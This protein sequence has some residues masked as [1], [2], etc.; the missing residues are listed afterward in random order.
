MRNADVRVIVGPLRSLEA[1]YFMES[2]GS[3]PEQPRQRL[4]NSAEPAHELQSHFEPLE[5]LVAGGLEHCLAELFEGIV[6]TAHSA[7]GKGKV[8][9]DAHVLGA[10][11]ERLLA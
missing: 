6:E 5:G 3:V 10:V 2:G 4:F 9:E 8:V 7:K 1:A 11:L